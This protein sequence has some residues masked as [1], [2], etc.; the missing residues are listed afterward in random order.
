MRLA[1]L[2]LDIALTHVLSRARQSI[3]GLLGVAM[4]VGFSVMMA[5]LMEGS[6]MRCR[7][8]RSATSAAV[9]RCSQ[10]RRCS[11]RSRSAG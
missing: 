8:S 11:M 5:A 7:I 10:P 4:G 2:A 1:K 9:R 3:V 6:S